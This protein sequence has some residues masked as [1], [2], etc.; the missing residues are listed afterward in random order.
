M[1]LLCVLVLWSLSRK[2][3]FG[4]VRRIGGK[5]YS[6]SSCVLAGSRNMATRFAEKAADVLVTVTHLVGTQC[7]T[8]ER[9]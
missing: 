8:R 6:K 3:T 7:A 9:L 5:S 2:F 1:I 4:A